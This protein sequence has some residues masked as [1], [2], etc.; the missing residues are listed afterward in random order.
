ML[1]LESGL[2][3]NSKII[4]FKNLY[5]E[6]VFNVSN[7]G[8]TEIISDPSY[9]SQFLVL[10]NPHIGN[11]GIIYQDLQSFKI[12]INLIII[13]CYSISSNFRC[14]NKVFIYLKKKK[15]PIVTNLD[16]RYLISNIKTIGSQFAT[17]KKKNI[18]KILIIK[19]L[20]FLN[21]QKI[22]YD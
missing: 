11:N 15:I 4:N 22:Y 5:G 18:K 9:K 16:T 8:Y 20:R 17:I 14:N 7:L 1:I 21:N 13:N 2:V 6:L 3:I 10:S 12:N 19:Y